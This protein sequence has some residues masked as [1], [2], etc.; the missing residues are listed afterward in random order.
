MGCTRAEVNPRTLA[1]AAGVLPSQWHEVTV[2]KILPKR[3][4]V[5]AAVAAAK[6]KP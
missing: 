1:A 4:A 3:D 6:G 5:R 2:E